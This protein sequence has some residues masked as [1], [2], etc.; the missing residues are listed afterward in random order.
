M[1]INN[2]VIVDSLEQ[3]YRI[4]IDDK[5]NMIIGGGAWIKLSVKDVNQL[6]S[7]DKLSLEYIREDGDYIEIGS[8]TS[9]RMIERHPLITNL[10]DG[11]LAKAIAKIMGVGIRN[12]AT[13]GGSIMGKFSFSDILP[14]LLVLNCDLKFY[15]RGRI[16]IDEFMNDKSIKDDILIS[17]SIKSIHGKSYFKKVSNTPLD[18]SWVNIAIIKNQNYSIAVGSRPGIAKLCYKAMAYL[19]QEKDITDQVIDLVLDKAIEE[20]ELSGNLRASQEYR[21]VLVRT[22]LKRGLKQVIK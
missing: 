19:N 11:I 7:L 14:V 3:A 12:L 5:K 17:I 9:L 2:Y 20:L 16:T 13:I 1:N 18:F 4:L 8:M 21:E 6:I 15:K 22:Y 10:C